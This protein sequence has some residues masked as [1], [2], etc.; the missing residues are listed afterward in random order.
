[1]RPVSRRTL[2]ALLGQ[3]MAA[4]A[5]ACA[6]GGGR[7]SATPTAAKTSPPASP[8]PLASPTLG[9]GPSLDEQ[10]A[11]MVMV[12]FRG[13]SAGPNDAIAVE[14]ERG[15]G[16]A[17]LF[18]Y[19]V[20]A[21]SPLRNIQSPEQLANLTAELRALATPPLLVA[22]DQEGGQ[23]VRLKESAGFPATLSEGFLGS[24]DILALTRSNAE[25]MAGAL[26]AAG[27][28]LN[29]APVVDL[30][31]NPSNPIIGAL[32][33]SFSADPDI[34]TAHALEEIRAHH[35]AGVL[36]ALKHF[37]GHG[38]STA[39]S[40]LGFV[41]VT[42]TWT[43]RELE[44]FANIIAAGEA[45][46]VMTAHVFNATLD[47]QYP[48][49]LSQATVTGILRDTL[50]FDGVIISDDMQMRAISDR[51]GYEDAVRLAVN[52]G[53]DILAIANNSVYEEGVAGRTM[54]II[55]AAVDRGDI[56]AER[57]AEAHGR[58]ARL[59]SRL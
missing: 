23:V 10:I 47:D 5:V 22:T 4:G 46:V 11:Q 27:V 33:R 50:G 45:D 15:L 56:A 59:K 41:D 18:D 38:S 20:P 28:N 12:G 7:E 25:T 8:V 32:D 31:V 57:I 51:Y 37:P 30:N 26:A 54:D 13:L 29:L 24:Q 52:A 16:G 34:V 39:D 43:R 48:A 3:A 36:C 14:L 19:D 35:R 6:R 17:V 21:G 2:L 53:V 1:M 49:T 58:I 42:D 55:R 40:H 44:P 9:G